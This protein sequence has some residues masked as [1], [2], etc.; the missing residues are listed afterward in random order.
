MIIIAGYS[1]KENTFRCIA[2]H[3]LDV[4]ALGSCVTDRKASEY[5]THFA[6]EKVAIEG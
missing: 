1:S 6:L 2:L 3:G 5:A 4:H